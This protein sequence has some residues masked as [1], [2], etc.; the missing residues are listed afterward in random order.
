[1]LLSVFYVSYEQ[2]SSCTC[3]ISVTTFHAAMI[4][5]KTS[6]QRFHWPRGTG[7]KIPANQVFCSSSSSVRSA[8]QRKVKGY[9]AAPVTNACHMTVTPMETVTRN[10]ICSWIWKG[11]TFCIELVLVQKCLRLSSRNF[12]TREMRFRRRPW[13]VARRTQLSGNYVVCVCLCV[14]YRCTYVW[15]LTLLLSLASVAGSIKLA[16]N[17]HFRLSSVLYTRTPLLVWN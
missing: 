16:L 3:M 9:Q 12:L 1:M 11:E 17:T 10:K 8:N 15:T 13:D 5:D 4:P 7:P 2:P 6:T 14:T